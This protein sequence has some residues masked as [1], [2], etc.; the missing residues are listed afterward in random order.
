MANIVL[1]L[2]SALKQIFFFHFLMDSVQYA[3]LFV[4]PRGRDEH[5]SEN[6]SAFFKRSLYSILVVVR[7]RRKRGKNGRTQNTRPE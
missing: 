2:F 5:R 7:V 4:E 3:S 1:T 6:I